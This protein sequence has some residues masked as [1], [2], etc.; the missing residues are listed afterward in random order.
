MTPMGISDES[1]L[2]GFWNR[3]LAPKFIQFRHVL[4]EGT[5]NHSAQVL[6]TLGLRGGERVI[7]IGCG[8]GDTSIE[9]ARLVGPEGAVC[10]VD[11]CTAFLEHARRDAEAAGVVNVTFV[12][13]DVQIHR[14]EPIHDV[15]FSRFGTQFFDN[16]VAG[17]RNL[18]TALRPGGTMT[19]IVWRALDENPC[20]NLPRQVVGEYLPALEEDADTCGPGP[21]SMAD[22]VLVRKQLESAGFEAI[23]FERVDAEVNMGETLDDAIAFHLAIGP[24][25]E[26]YREA[27][28]VAEER[29]AEIVAALKRE[30]AA[31]ETPWGII[32]PSSSWK[33]TARNP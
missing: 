6:P 15:A 8:F 28:A 29:H 22:E 9:L 14:F 4:V 20:M 7:D 2:V 11:C 5:S 30:L 12:E 16:P 24:A 17:L 21:F 26:L 31:F 25:G 32:M 23:E 10:G 19:M 33:V 27:G 18:S 1:E 3:V 13:A